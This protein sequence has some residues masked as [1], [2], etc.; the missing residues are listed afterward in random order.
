M[1]HDSYGMMWG[2]GLIWLLVLILLVLAIA[3]L[4]KFLFFRRRKDD[5]NG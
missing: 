1:M 5:G 4:V 3:A 2:T